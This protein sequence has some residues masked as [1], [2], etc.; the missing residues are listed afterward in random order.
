MAR[1]AQSKSTDSILSATSLSASTGDRP[2]R[3]SFRA[4]PNSRRVGSG[5]SEPTA[6]S[7][8]SKEYPARS[9]VEMRLRVSGSCEMNWARSRLATKFT[10]A[11]ATIKVTAAPIRAPMMPP[12]MIPVNTPARIAEARAPAIA[13]PGRSGMFAWSRADSMLPRSP[14]FWA[15]VSAC[16]TKR[17][18]SGLL[19]RPSDCWPAGA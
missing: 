18:R 3:V 9:E 17:L 8:C 10:A 6:S 5:A 11:E 13:S 14:R 19:N 15:T 4:R 16:L 2:R 1:T 7:A 12:V